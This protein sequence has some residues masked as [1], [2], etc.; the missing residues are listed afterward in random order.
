VLRER[1][2]Q[3][4]HLFHRVRPERAREGREIE[5]GGWKVVLSAR[6]RERKRGG[7]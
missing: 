7:A 3:L 4:A 2:A 5:R 6:K 1:Q